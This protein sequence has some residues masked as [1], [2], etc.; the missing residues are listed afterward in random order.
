MGTVKQRLGYSGSKE[1]Q[2]GAWLAGFATE[3][4]LPGAF[5]VAKGAKAMDVSKQA[6]GFT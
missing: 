6:G 2:L 1:R 3:A 5:C 4:G